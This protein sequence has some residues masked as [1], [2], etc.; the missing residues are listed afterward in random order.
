MT[1]NDNHVKP[2]AI[3]VFNK[4]ARVH[5]G[6]SLQIQKNFDDLIAKDAVKNRG[7]AGIFRSKAFWQG[8]RD[9]FAAPL[10]ALE[11][12]T[13]R[14]ARPPKRVERQQESDPDIIKGVEFTDAELDTLKKYI[15]DNVLGRGEEYALK[16]G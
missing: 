16:A 15:P 9:G 11:S 3:E 10:Y 13:S 4:I 7:L 5:Y 1:Y 14:R 12:L 6:A 2:S 8:F